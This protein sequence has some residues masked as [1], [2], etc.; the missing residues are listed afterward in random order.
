MRAAVHAGEGLPPELVDLTPVE[1]QPNDVVVDVLASGVCHTDLSVTRGYLPVPPGTILGHEGVG[2]VVAIGDRVRGLEPGDRVITAFAPTC[3]NCWY[4]V[5]GETHLCAKADAIYATPRA[6]HADGSTS[7]A[8]TGLG[9]FA[10]Q[11]TVDEASLVKIDSALPNDQ[12]ALLGCGV[13]TGL[14]AV[15]NTATVSPGSSM[16]VLGCGGVGQA[17]IQAGRLAGAITIVA[18]DPVA[19]KRDLALQ[20]GATVVVDPTVDKPSTVVRA[21]TDGRGCDFAFEAVG[22]GASIATA[23]NL[24]R[25][26]GTVVAIGVP[27]HAE[28][29]ELAAARLFHEGKRLIGSFYGSAQVRRDLPRYA[30]LAESGHLNLGALISR[31]IDLD[32]IGEA[33]EWVAQGLQLRAVIVPGKDAA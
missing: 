12:L 8:F 10:D 19:A 3:R 9:T 21:C 30:A 26:G 6:R 4:C 31:R 5:N 7:L 16:V 20:S 23:Y 13:T 1:P 27:H 2:R 15:L 24:T 22:S 14:G 29:L 33:L 28:K 25:R 18:V 17:V 32:Q 11:M